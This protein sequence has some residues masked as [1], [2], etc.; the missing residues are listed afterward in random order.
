[1]HLP[2]DDQR[3]WKAAREDARKSVTEVLQLA[4]RHDD[5]DLLELGCE[6]R[7]RYLHRPFDMKNLQ[8]IRGEADWA[9]VEYQLRRG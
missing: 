7:D 8:Q 4:S 6:L 1:M 3:K 9:V 2:M 5:T